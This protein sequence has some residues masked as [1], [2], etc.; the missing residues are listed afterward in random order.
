MQ[1]VEK[2]D[3]RNLVEHLGWAYGLAELAATM[4]AGRDE[5]GVPDQAILDLGP[6]TVRQSAVATSSRSAPLGLMQ[7]SCSHGSWGHFALEFGTSLAV[8]I[9]SRDSNS[10]REPTPCLRRIELVCARAV[11]GEIQSL[12]AI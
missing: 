2:Q 10:N 8:K 9:V 11:E 3:R 4:A 5:L 7:H 1:I 6:G 12:R